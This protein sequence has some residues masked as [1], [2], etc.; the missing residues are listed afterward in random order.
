MRGQY[1]ASLLLIFTTSLTFAQAQSQSQPQ[2]ADTI[3]TTTRL[4]TMSVVVRDKHG[5]P[6]RGLS[7]D[8]FEVIDGGRPQSVRVLQEIDN[9]AAHFIAKLPPD[10]YSNASNQLGAPPSVTAIVFDTLLTHWDAQ[11]YALTQVRALLRGIQPQDRVGLYVI[12]GDPWA[13]AGNEL[14]VLQDFTQDTSPLVAA[15][16]HYDAEQEAKKRHDKNAVVDDRS[17]AIP[18]LDRFLSGGDVH[19]RFALEDATHTGGKNYSDWAKSVHYAVITA[20][21]QHMSTAPGRKSIVWVSDTTPANLFVNNDLNALAARLESQFGITDR[22]EI[23]TFEDMENNTGAFADFGPMTRRLNKLGVA[24]YP[25]AAEGLDSLYLS[26]QGFR[27]LIPRPMTA[28]PIPDI[29]PPTTGSSAFTVPNVR[30]HAGMRIVADRTGGHAFFNSNDLT[31]GIRQA[32]DDAQDSYTIGFYPDHGKWNGE[33]RGVHVKVKRSGLTVRAREGYVA[34][35]DPKPLPASKEAYLVDQLAANPLQAADIPFTVKITPSAAREN[36]SVTAL[37]HFEPAHWLANQGETWKGNFKV[38]CTLVDVKN[39]VL[40]RT[41]KTVDLNL[42]KA[43]FQQVSQR[44]VDLPVSI[45]LKPGA[46]VLSVIVED[47]NSRDVG[48]VRIPM[49]KYAPM[50]AQASDKKP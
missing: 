11:K 42:T 5:N 27:P 12:G 44:G 45:D 20:I 26:Q 30:E 43:T 3:R 25:V 34:M 15:I 13:P 31:T 38:V 9:Q 1:F 16:R 22:L 48:S 36:P 41:T 17:T 33:F 10:T 49:E 50:Q 8:D 18:E 21:A 39:Y 47:E 6:V 24:L 2:P 7:K 14:K 23:H 37:V 35:A 4:V 46:A 29:L 32:L 40:E 19:Y 28:G